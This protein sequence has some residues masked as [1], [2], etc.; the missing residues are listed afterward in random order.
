MHSQLS[1]IGIQDNLHL[2]DMVTMTPREK[3][4]SA[5][6]EYLAC[7]DTSRSG[8]VYSI[9][10]V[11]IMGMYLKCDVLEV[12]CGL[13]QLPNMETKAN[14]L[15]NVKD[16]I[17]VFE[18]EL[19]RFKT[20]KLS[21]IT[22]F[23][24]PLSLIR[25]RAACIKM[26]LLLILD[27]NYS[28]KEQFPLKDVTER[29]AVV[30]EYLEKLAA[31]E[32][33]KMDQFR[34]STKGKFENGHRLPEAVI[35]SEKGVVLRPPRRE[36]D[37]LNLSVLETQYVDVQHVKTLIAEQV[38]NTLSI[39]RERVQSLYN[40][41][42]YQSTPNAPFLNIYQREKVKTS[43]LPTISIPKHHSQIIGDASEY[44]AWNAVVQTLSIDIDHCLL[45]QDLQKRIHDVNWSLG[46]KLIE[47]TCASH[48]LNLSMN[49]PRFGLAMRHYW[50]SVMSIYKSV[51]HL[52]GWLIE[53][54]L[55]L[56]FVLEPDS[57]Q[58]TLYICSDSCSLFVL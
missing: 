1:F 30:E 29:V 28:E 50:G 45:I 16:I 43:L 10:V 23:E 35:K 42:Q 8:K 14:Y 19:E 20:T 18:K 33:L 22:A 15:L 54:D 31:I 38:E 49:L 41:I 36:C 52:H 11:E 39:R 5:V 34:I 12:I 44:L 37:W 58:G 48:Y 7:M 2:I 25:T 55:A 13:K 17:N 21:N 46:S 24:I 51:I 56:V 6:S 57:D 53:S 4:E 3:L 40:T 27:Q 26:G 47:S 9:A 32:L